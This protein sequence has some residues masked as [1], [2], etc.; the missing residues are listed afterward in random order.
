MTTLVVLTQELFS[1]VSVYKNL[2]AT[3]NDSIRLASDRLLI[4]FRGEFTAP[5]ETQNKESILSTFGVE[6][7]EEADFLR[8]EGKFGAEQ[9]ALLYN[10]LGQ[11]R[12]RNQIEVS[13]ENLRK[14]FE[15]GN[16]FC[17]WNGEDTK[18]YNSKSR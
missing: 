15:E 7:V 12:R 14:V 5:V 2:F 16:L 4:V 8:L 9:K 6:R 10:K 17:V 18:K 11:F 1:R 13:F 3:P